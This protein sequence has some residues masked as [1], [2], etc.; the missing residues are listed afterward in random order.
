MQSLSNTR[1]QCCSGRALVAA[2]HRLGLPVPCHRQH[3]RVAAAQQ[4]S[5]TV[6]DEEAQ[7]KKM[8]LISLAAS[9][10]GGI[11]L[12][13]L[14]MDE[15]LPDWSRQASSALGWSYVLAWSISFYPQVRQQLVLGAV[16]QVLLT[17]QQSAPCAALPPILLAYTQHSNPTHCHQRFGHVGVCVTDMLS[18][19][20]HLIPCV[21]SWPQQQRGSTW[22]MLSR[23]PDTTAH[24]SHT[25]VSPAT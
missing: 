21:H 19:R 20:S 16:V 15:A 10:G 5:N 22:D 17:S 3:R 7:D 11:L 23:V 1:V 24:A 18:L 25:L 6:E 9:I 4:Q 14:G 2:Q 8:A 13:Q 12:S